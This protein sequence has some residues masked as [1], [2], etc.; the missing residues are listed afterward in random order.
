MDYEFMFRLRKAI[1]DKGITAS[2]LSRIS[3]VGKSDISNYLKGKYVPKQDKCYMLANA[4]GV[5]PG[6][7]MTGYVPISEDDTEEV[8]PVTDEARILARGI[9][10]LPKEQREQALAMFRIMFAPQYADLFN[11]GEDE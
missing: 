11:K 5:D 9:D 1:A 8:I 7:L 6:W 4:L 3:G 10:R 2:E